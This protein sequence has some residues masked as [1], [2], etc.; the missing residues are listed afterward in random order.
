MFSLIHQDKNTAARLGKLAVSH[1]EIETPCFM[2]VG[3]QGT[4]KAVTPKGLVDSGA[5]IILSNAYHL[6]LRPG[7]EIEESVETFKD[8]IEGHE[9]LDG[10]EIELADEVVVGFA[11]STSDAPP[12]AENG[13]PMTEEELLQQ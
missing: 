13:I 3:T 1:G 8:I 10:D 7:M 4:V 11:A 6:F 9:V 12:T 2:P 5:Q